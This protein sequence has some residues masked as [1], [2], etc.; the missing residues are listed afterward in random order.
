MK[1]YCITLRSKWGEPYNVT[2]PGNSLSEV[3]GQITLDPDWM[4][5][6]YS[7]LGVSA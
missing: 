2:L 4:F 1:M 3:L 6:S 5:G 7:I